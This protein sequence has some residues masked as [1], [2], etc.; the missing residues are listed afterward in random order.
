MAS[1]FDPDYVSHCLKA[2]LKQP[3]PSSAQDLPQKTAA[4][5]LLLQVHPVHGPTTLWIQR[6]ENPRDPWSGHMGFPGGRQEEA[7]K[8]SL[9][10]AQR[11]TLEEIGLDL[12]DS[13]YLGPLQQ[14]PVYSRKGRAAFKLAAH[15]FWLP[16]APRFTLESREVA[17]IHEIPMTY[18]K[19]P[20]NATEKQIV[21]KEKPM[22]FPAIRFRDRLLWGLS[23]KVW[24]DL[25][26]RI[27]QTSLGSLL[28]EQL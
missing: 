16:Q 25:A 2:A 22:Q 26:S 3:A 20:Q 11:E 4:V 12:K 17:A 5:S 10:T 19:D 7:D 28:K 14:H 24:L 13:L 21:W 18:L 6:A 8:D 9:E 23:L 27:D 15:A 1:L